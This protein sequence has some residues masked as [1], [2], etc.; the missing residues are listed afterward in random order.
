M[1][2]KNAALTTNSASVATRRGVHSRRAGRSGNAIL[3]PTPVELTRTPHRTK[4]RAVWL[5]PRQQR[6]FQPEPEC[7]NG[8]EGE[9]ADHIGHGGHERARGHRRVEP[10]PVE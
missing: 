4:P 10:Q 7:R 8:Q 3:M 1:A 5:T 2:Q 6:L 9:E